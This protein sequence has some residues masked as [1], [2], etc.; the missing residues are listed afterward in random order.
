[1][2]SYRIQH[3]SKTVVWLMRVQGCEP[4]PWQDWC[5]NWVPILFIFRYGVYILVFSKLLLFAFFGSFWTVFRWFRVLVGLYRNPHP[6]T[7][8]FLKFFLNVGEGPLRWPVGLF[9]LRF[10]AWPKPLA[11]QLVYNLFFL[12]NFLLGFPKNTYN[13]R[14]FSNVT[15]TTASLPRQMLTTKLFTMHFAM[16]GFRKLWVVWRLISLTY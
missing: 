3:R 11:R 7:L 1:M 14:G 5:K 16:V 13:Q 9:Q 12:S 4:P 15:W 6:D 10:P 2:Y 8:S